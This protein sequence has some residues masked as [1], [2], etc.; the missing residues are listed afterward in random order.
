MRS[1]AAR[2]G[3]V[4]VSLVALAWFISLTDNDGWLTLWFL[5]FIFVGIPL[6]VLTWVD[7]GRTLRQVESPTRLTFVLGVFFGLPQAAFGLIA[8]ACGIS[9]IAWVAYNSFVDW[10]PQYTG[11]FLTFGL[12]PALV[13]F[14]WY[15]LREAFVKSRADSVRDTGP[16]NALERTRDE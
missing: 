8:V 12:G 7:L 1:A 4:V 13:L 3:L 11:G 2:L 16:N 14:G 6:F 15:W 5:L 9:I 10:Q